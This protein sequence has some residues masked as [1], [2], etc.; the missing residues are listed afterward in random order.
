MKGVMKIYLVEE[1]TFVISQP[2]RILACF[3]HM[4]DAAKHAEWLQKERGVSTEIHERTL[5]NG[6][7]REI[8]VL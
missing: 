8:H 1:D 7:Q 4:E 2:G 5:L 6:Q 3:R